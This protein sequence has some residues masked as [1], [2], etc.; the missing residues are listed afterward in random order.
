MAHFLPSGYK[1]NRTLRVSRYKFDR[2][3]ETVTVQDLYL[4][5]WRSVAVQTISKP[6]NCHGA[7]FNCEQMSVS[8]WKNYYKTVLG[9][10]AK[11]KSVT[12]LLTLPSVLACVFFTKFGNSL[13]ILLRHHLDFLNQPLQLNIHLLNRL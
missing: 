3:R 5:H 12:S 6:E 9:A 4:V 2:S 1:F 7:G 11:A 13:N 10:G 8:G